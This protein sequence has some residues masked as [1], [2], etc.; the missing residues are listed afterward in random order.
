L[1]GTRIEQLRDATGGRD[2]DIRLENKLVDFVGDGSDVAIRFGDGAWP[3][4]EVS[5]LF[6][7]RFFPVCS[8][9]FLKEHPLAHPTELHGVPLLRHTHPLWSWP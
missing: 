1:A 5:S 3:G 4:F 2:L 9:A 6:R 8:P 7:V